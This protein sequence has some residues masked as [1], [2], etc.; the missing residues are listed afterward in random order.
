M[1]NVIRN[2]Q[3]LIQDPVETNYRVILEKLIKARAE[4][5]YY[6]KRLKEQEEEFERQRYRAEAFQKEAEEVLSKARQEA[7]R[8]VEQAN[9][10]AQSILQQARESGYKEG[11]E[12]GLL[13]AQREYEKLLEELEVQKVMIL[14]ERENMLKELE[15]KILLLIPH[16]L[17]KVLEREI[18]D[19]SFLDQ[20]I[21]NAVLQLSIRS[22]LAIKV[23]EDDYEYVTNKL[24]EILRGV[25]GVDRVD[26]KID[27]AL[28]SGDVVIETPYGFV[29]TGI[30]MRLE[31]IQ[32]IILSLLG[33]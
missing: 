22:N 14:K 24:D 32:E 16:I 27:K 21:K 33:D 4:I 23:S 5:E 15:D 19:K 9:I 1:S 12:K 25:D 29:E 30:K 13:D 17:E 6:E 20:Y 3:V 28:K 2:N 10:Q 11:F 8:I 18:N 31:K 26:V 7:Q